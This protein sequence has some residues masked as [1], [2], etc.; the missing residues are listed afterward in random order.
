MNYTGRILLWAVMDALKLLLS[1]LQRAI[2]GFVP[3][4]ASTVVFH[5]Q[6]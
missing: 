3:H 1:S 5:D 2:T 4:P 6:I